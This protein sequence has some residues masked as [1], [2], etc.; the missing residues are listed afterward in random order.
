MTVGQNAW[1]KSYLLGKDPT[2]TSGYSNSKSDLMKLD[3]TK[4]IVKGWFP[5]TKRNSDSTVKP[6][7]DDYWLNK[8]QPRCKYEKLCSTTVHHFTEIC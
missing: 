7:T 5:Y 4:T 8:D 3:N 1:P 2:T 6:K